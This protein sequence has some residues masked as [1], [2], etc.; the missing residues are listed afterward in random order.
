MNS[1]LRANCACVAVVLTALLCVSTSY[2]QLKLPFRADRNAAGVGSDG[3]MLNERSGPWLVMCASFSGDAGVR[4]AENLAEELR[5][6]H[7][8]KAYVFRHEFDHTKKLQSSAIPTWTIDENSASDHHI[9]QAKMEP[10]TTASYEEVAVMVG[11]FP[12]IDDAQAQKTLSKIKTL[13]A[14]S[15]DASLTGAAE[16]DLSAERIRQ[17]RS[18]SENLPE[19]NTTGN[20][21]FRA[22][23]LLPNPML[24]EEYFESQKLDDFVIGLNKQRFIKHSLLKNPGIYTVRVASFQGEST[25]NIGEIEEKE[26]EMKWLRRNKKSVQS[27]KLAEAAHKAHLLT[28]EFRKLGVEA[29]EFHD[30]N[31]SFVC[32]GSFD[33]IVRDDG[34]SD[35]TQN[36]EVVALILKYK[37]EIKHFPGRPNTAVPYSF[38]SLAKEKI[39]CDAQPYPVLVPKVA[40]QS[41][42]SR[43]LNRFR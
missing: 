3:L 19:G 40:K 2:A 7:G 28:E 31:E 10:A 35:K 5:S 39:V 9:V 32:L 38:P 30:R 4:R 22:A 17:W 33:W 13:S 21:A 43:L 18:N 15:M 37:A 34:A 42:A 1:S 20:G 29:Y 14:D 23:F 27:S 6:R 8:L 16:S 26:R 12:A 36:P 41:S 24:P 25:F 11:D